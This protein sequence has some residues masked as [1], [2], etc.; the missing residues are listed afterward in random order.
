MLSNSHMMCLMRIDEKAPNRQ[1]LPNQTA[2]TDRGDSC[3]VKG[4]VRT[5][6]SMNSINAWPKGRNM[7]HALGMML[8]SCKHVYCHA[9]IYNSNAEQRCYP[10]CPE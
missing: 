3:L 2:I 1:R 6:K 10:E 9:R 4:E 7:S 5:A 8:G